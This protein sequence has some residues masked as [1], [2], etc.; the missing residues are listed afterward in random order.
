MNSE[1]YK[2]CYRVE[3]K[4]I[5]SRKELFLSLKKLFDIKDLSEIDVI[6]AEKNNSKWFIHIKNEETFEKYLHKEIE[7]YEQI[8]IL[9]NANDC[10]LSFKILWLPPAFNAQ[11]VSSYVSEVFKISL[12]D[13]VDI[14]DEKCKE[15]EMEHISNGNWTVAF[16]VN[17]NDYN[18]NCFDGGV[19]YLNNIKSL[20]IKKGEKPK[21]LFCNQIGHIRKLCPKLALFCVKCKKKGHI[22]ECCSILDNYLDIK[23]ETNIV[24]N[25]LIQTDNEA[26]HSEPNDSE[27]NISDDENDSFSSKSD[28]SK[29]FRRISINS[30]TFIDNDTEGQSFDRIIE[31]VNK[32][33]E[34]ANITAFR[35]EVNKPESGMGLVE[36][37]LKI[38]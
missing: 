3:C 37:I 12:K 38:L 27:R 1:Y 18:K 13:I 2:N 16:K 28:Y 32:D 24:Q 33:L 31:D 17:S 23:L 8:H 34:A 25:P 21:C 22:E 20:F 11:N 36:F 7:I 6:T 15:S 26:F 30:G 5:L 19:K 4:T 35:T 14:R 29:Q 9:E 10:I